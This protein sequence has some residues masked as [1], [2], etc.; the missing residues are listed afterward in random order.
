MKTRYKFC[1]I[2]DLGATWNR[3]DCCLNIVIGPK[4]AD[5]NLKFGENALTF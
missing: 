3:N 4:A 1:V 2:N 5:T